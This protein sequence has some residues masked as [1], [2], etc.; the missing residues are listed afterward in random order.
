MLHQACQ[1]LLKLILIPVSYTHLDVYKRQLVFLV[2]I[3]VSIT[4]ITRKEDEPIIEIGP[5]TSRTSASFSNVQEKLKNMTP[6]QEKLFEQKIQED[7]IQ[8]NIATHEAGIKAI[9]YEIGLVE[10]MLILKKNTMSPEEVRSAESYI[11]LLYT[12][13]CV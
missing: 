7:R 12:S 13:R 8:Q 4:L 1:H 6:E 3:L 2:I 10:T 9:K 5:L 11:C